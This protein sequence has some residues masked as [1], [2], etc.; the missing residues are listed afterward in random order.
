MDIAGTASSAPRMPPKC[1]PAS[2]EKTT[3]TGWIFAESPMIFGF[4]RFASSWWI[5]M[6]HRSTKRPV[7]KLCVRP[8]ST[9]GS[10]ESTVP[11]IG[12]IENIVAITASVGQYFRSASAKPMAES[13]P[14]TPQMMSCPRTT[15]D[16]PRSMLRKNSSNAPRDGGGTR[17]RRKPKIFASVTSR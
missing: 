15:P 3:S 17:L 12:M 9:A 5:P 1:S 13:A 2:S 7:P 14:F 8:R 4:R 10:D 11:K 6:I 16:S